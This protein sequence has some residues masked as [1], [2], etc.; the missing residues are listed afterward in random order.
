[1]GKKKRNADSKKVNT[2]N[3]IKELLFEKKDE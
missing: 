1:M 3:Q 2:F